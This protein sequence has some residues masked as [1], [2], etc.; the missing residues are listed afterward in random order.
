MDCVGVG[1]EPIYF[2]SNTIHIIYTNITYY[3]LIR[4]HAPLRIPKHAPLHNPQTP[5]TLP[6]PAVSPAKYHLNIILIPIYFTQNIT[7]YL[8][9]LNKM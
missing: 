2:I 7:Y 4:K 8:Y 9:Y 3:N 6:P 1:Y 5:N